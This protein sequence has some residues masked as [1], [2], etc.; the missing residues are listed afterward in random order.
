MGE[1]QGG[2]N[3]DEPQFIPDGPCETRRSEAEPEDSFNNAN[4][5]AIIWEPLH[6]SYEDC[7]WYY[8]VFAPYD[9][10][11][12]KDSEWFSNYAVDKARKWASTKSKAFY[13]TKEVEATKVHANL[14]ICSASDLM[15]YHG[16]SAYN[17]YRM[18][19]NELCT[20]GDRQRVLAYILKE[21]ENR[22][23]KLY[24]D[25]YYTK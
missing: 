1:L 23:F 21:S 13:V 12:D 17:K 19:V 2:I 4:N 7:K 14:L 3:W 10:A 15:K 22:S 24:Q 11:Y 5:N 25:Y 16:K 20:L 9:K 18:N 6:R 8:I